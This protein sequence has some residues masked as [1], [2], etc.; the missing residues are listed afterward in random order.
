MII[1]NICSSEKINASQLN[2]L[3]LK[4][5][6]VLHLNSELSVKHLTMPDKANIIK[7]TTNK[8]PM[9]QGKSLH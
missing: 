6:F 9:G 8:E 4:T 7:N 2:Y 3:V 1:I 5:P